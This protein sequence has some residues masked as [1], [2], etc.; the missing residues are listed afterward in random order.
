MLASALTLVVA[1]R[2]LRRL[3]PKCGSEREI[4]GGERELFLRHDIDPPETVRAA[5][6]CDACHG[7]GYR[8]RIGIYEMLAV[9]SA[10]Q[11]LIFG[12]ALKSRIEEE[13]AAKG[14]RLLFPQ[15]LRKAQQ[16]LTTME[17]VH[18]VVAHG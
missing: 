9:D 6:G 13:M 17:E 7:S 4:E 11:E 16:Q 18:R 15:A 8:G 3:C 1:Q 14:A 12:C 10:M 2:L 5:V